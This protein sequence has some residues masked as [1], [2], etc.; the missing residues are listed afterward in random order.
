MDQTAIFRQRR[1]LRAWRGWDGIAERGAALLLGW[2]LA[3]G[4]AGAVE[5]ADL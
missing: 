5:K 1:H 2:L 4:P 3:A